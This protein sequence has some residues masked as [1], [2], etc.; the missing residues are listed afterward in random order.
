[1]SYLIIVGTGKERRYYMMSE[2][3]WDLVRPTV[4]IA[5][6]YGMKVRVKPVK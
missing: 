4:K 5:K 6:Q 1:M 2:E 3:R